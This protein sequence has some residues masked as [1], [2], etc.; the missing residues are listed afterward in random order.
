M[1]V[2]LRVYSSEKESEMETRQG[3]GKG[4]EGPTGRENGKK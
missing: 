3:G 2:S 4:L 1:V